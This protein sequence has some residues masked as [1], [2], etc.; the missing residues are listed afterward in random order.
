TLW[1][2]SRT[3]RAPADGLEAER[4]RSLRV[5][6]FWSFAVACTIGFAEWTFAQGI[7]QLIML[8]AAMGFALAQ[9][10]VA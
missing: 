3:A 9:E 6:V 4:G 7:G 10:R 8:V 5:T 2:L 1:T